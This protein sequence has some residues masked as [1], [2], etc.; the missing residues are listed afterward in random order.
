[1]N[2]RS[3][4]LNC[5]IL[6]ENQLLS[7]IVPK[8]HFKGRKSGNYFLVYDDKRWAYDLFFEIPPFEVI[9][10]ES[11]IEVD[12]IVDDIYDRYDDVGK[13]GA[14][15]MKTDLKD[16]DELFN[17]LDIESKTNFTHQQK[18]GYIIMKLNVDWLN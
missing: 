4:G 3:S 2:Q 10:N 8:S 15:V 18:V 12:I 7:C 5:E 6:G 14:V 9:L 13:K 1:M 11:N 16:E 17:S